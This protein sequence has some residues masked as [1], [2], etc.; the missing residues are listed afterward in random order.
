MLLVFRKEIKFILCNV[1][2]HYY[3]IIFQPKT[4]DCAVHMYNIYTRNKFENQT[5]CGHI[6]L[7]FYSLVCGVN[8]AICHQAD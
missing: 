7:F 1:C 3:E 2:R 5:L 6:L 8:R 4:V